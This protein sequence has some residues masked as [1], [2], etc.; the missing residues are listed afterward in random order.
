MVLSKSIFYL[1]FNFIEPMHAKFD[2]R[3]Q[4]YVN[5]YG[6]ACINYSNNHNHNIERTSREMQHSE[7]INIYKIFVAGAAYI[8]VCKA[9]ST[10]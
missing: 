1:A 2:T 9:R 6:K 4:M 8:E 10:I 7:S 3:V 5:R